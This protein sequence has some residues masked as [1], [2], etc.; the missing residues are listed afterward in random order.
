[1]IGTPENPPEVIAVRIATDRGGVDLQFLRPGASAQ[2]SL[3]VSAVDTAEAVGSGSVPALATPRVLELMERAAVQ[4]VAGA[5]E[6]GTTSVGISVGLSHSRATPVGNVV[7]ATATLI[8]VDGRRLDFEVLVVD[9]ASGAE[10]AKA[11]HSRLVVDTE[12]FLRKLSGS[13]SQN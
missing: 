7:E 10:V 12:S 1:L 13:V 4:A 8:A 5:L 9:Q 6:A 3:L 2:V 11:T